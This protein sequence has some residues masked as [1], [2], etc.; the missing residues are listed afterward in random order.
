MGFDP[1]L[2]VGDKISFRQMVTIFKCQQ[3][4]GMLRSKQNNA[5]IIISN[6]TKGIYRDVWRK[7]GVLLYTGMGQDGDQILEGN[8]NKTLYESRTN[9]VIVYLFE[10]YV[11][12]EYL[13][14]G[15]VE[16]MEN[17]YQDIQIDRNGNERKVWIFPVKPIEDSSSIEWDEDEKLIDKIAGLTDEEL[18][19]IE[20]VYTPEPEEKGAPIIRN[21]IQIYP[22]NKKRA[23]NA[24]SSAGFVCEIDELH[25]TFIRK[26]SS[27]NYVE[28]H[29]LVPMKYSKHFEHSLDVEA[30]IVS[31]CSNCHNQLHYGRDY[32]ILLRKLYDNREEV[33]YKAGIKVTYD[34]LKEMYENI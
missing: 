26:N 12:N 28:P 33:L 2:Q 11:K 4:G 9:G 31:L 15:I 17:P 25:P 22:R 6:Y 3:Q 8:Q 14:R 32:E 23:M 1:G 29:H 5:L 16:L 18:N 21:N 24:L 30:N 20:Y 34:E 7:D 19:S 13:Y 10:V 27:K